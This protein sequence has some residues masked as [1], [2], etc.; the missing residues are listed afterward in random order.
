MFSYLWIPA[1]VVAS[2]FQVARN[3]LQRGLMPAT[4][5]W[6]ATLVRFL[7][8]LPF[9]LL[10]AGLA[11]MLT[12]GADLRFESGFWVSAIVGA[13]G[14]VVATASLLVAMR[15]AGFA[16]ATAVQQSSLPL[17]AFIG[18]LVYHDRLGALAWAGVAVTTAGLGVLT[19]PRQ[20]AGMR[21][22][23]GAAFS[24]VSGLC[25]GFTLNA[26]RHAT[27]ALDA[28]HPIFAALV[29]VAVVQAMQSAALTAWLAV[30][31]PAAL[32]AVAAGWRQS[33]GAGFCGAC[34]SAGWFTALALAAAAPVRAVGVIEAPIAAFAGRRFFSERLQLRQ[35]AAGAAVLAG[36]VMTTLG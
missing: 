23:S 10:F 24:L 30:R 28:A 25:F 7:F 13:A 26:F 17:A 34:A 21:P 31:D 5:P 14:Q 9:A 6:G 27:L 2:V 12:P 15:R 8:G 4:G 33:V 11:W 20:A 32:R 19:W 22:A 36:V 35:V 29:C 18:L 3:G 16:V 1:T